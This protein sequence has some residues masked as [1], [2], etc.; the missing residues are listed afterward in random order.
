LRL[1]RWR[2]LDVQVKRGVEH[3]LDLH[4]AE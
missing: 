2:A 3:R 1:A 4:L